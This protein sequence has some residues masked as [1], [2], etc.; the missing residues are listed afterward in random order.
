MHWL[1]QYVL[2]DVVIFLLL[3]MRELWKVTCPSLAANDWAE[4][5]AQP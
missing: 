5:A 1:V 3:Q 4:I 2:M